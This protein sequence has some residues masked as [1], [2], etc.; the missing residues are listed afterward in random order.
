MCSERF[1]TSHEECEA[2][3]DVVLVFLHFLR[4]SHGFAAIMKGFTRFS[5]VT[6]MFWGVLKLSHWF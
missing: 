3:S 1:Q 5:G 2:F 6:L 4:R